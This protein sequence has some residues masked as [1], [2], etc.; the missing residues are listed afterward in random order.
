MEISR[1]EHIRPQLVET[2][3]GASPELPQDILMDI[4]AT[5]EIPDLVRAGSVCSSWRSASSRLRSLGHY[6]RPQ[7]PCL[8]YSSESSGESVACL[9]SLAEKRTYK[10]TL[11]GP[12]IRSRHLIGSSQGLLVTVDD[13]SEMHLVNP[14]TGEQIDLPSVIT[15]EHVKPI[16]NDSGAL[17]KYE[18]SCH[19]AKMVHGPRSILALEE[20]R[21]QLPSP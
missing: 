10:L 19:T 4:F 15:I 5:L 21:N 12:P 1:D 3:E 2:T 17:H 18:Y 20:L 14:I 7:T 11:P 6:M 8:L 9:Y 13:R 16:Y